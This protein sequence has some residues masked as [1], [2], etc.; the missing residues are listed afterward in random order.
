MSTLTT[1]RGNL[2]DDLKDLDSGDYAWTDAELERHVSH[3]ISEYERVWPKLASVTKNGD[4]SSRRFNL[5]GE[6]LYLWTERVEHEIDQ[7]PPSYLPFHEE[8]PG[9]V[10]ILGDTVP[11]TGVN[12]VKFWYAKRYTVNSSSSDLP[13]EHEAGALLGAAVYALASYAR[14]A[15]RR[16]NVTGLAPDLLRN[17]YESRLAEFN[18]WLEKLRTQRGFEPG[19]RASWRLPNAKRSDT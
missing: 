19:W 2:R 5:A 17:L 1:L 4:G 7:D 6:S 12:N 18:Q 3:A 13:A 15:T 10:Y 16:V 14:Y 11:A 9:S 8:T